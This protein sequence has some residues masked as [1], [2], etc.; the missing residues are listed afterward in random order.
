MPVSVLVVDDDAQFRQLAVRTLRS[1]GLAVIAEAGTCEEALA[2]TVELQPDAALVDIGLPDGDGFGL[3][4]QL[5]RL[6][7]PPRVV[8]ISSD[9]DS[10]NGSSAR[11]AGAAGFFPKDE[12]VGSELRRLISGG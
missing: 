5:T 3:A 10:A 1:W 8:L 11:Q 6:S 7:S 2:L 4:Q 12:L 9:S